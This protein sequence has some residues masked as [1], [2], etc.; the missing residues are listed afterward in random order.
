MHSRLTSLVSR[1]VKSNMLP[2]DLCRDKGFGL[3]ECL[4]VLAC[5]NVT[6]VVDERPCLS[7]C[8]L[9]TLVVLAHKNKPTLMIRRR[10]HFRYETLRNFA[11]RTWTVSHVANGGDEN[12]ETEINRR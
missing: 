3:E 10:S 4:N 11:T 6:L 1:R 9:T 7:D 5:D 12:S 8:M 2:T